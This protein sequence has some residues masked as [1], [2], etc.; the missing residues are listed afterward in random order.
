MLSYIMRC[1][2]VFI[3]NIINNNKELFALDKYPCIINEFAPNLSVLLNAQDNE[4]FCPANMLF[5]LC[6]LFFNVSF[7]YI[8]LLQL[9]LSA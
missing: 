4:I 5:V 1:Y 9:W 6:F 2:K 8:L 7:S 3:K